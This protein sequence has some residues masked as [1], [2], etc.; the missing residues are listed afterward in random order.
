MAGA[1]VV[2][3]DAW[4]MPP[5]PVA[6]LLVGIVV[7]WNVA[8]GPLSVSLY[9]LVLLVMIGPC[10]WRWL[11]GGAGRVRVTDIALVLFCL[12]CCL[13]LAVVHGPGRAIEAGGMLI[14]ETAGTYFLARCYIRTVDDFR[15]TAGL[16]FLLIAFVA[17]FALV[18]AITGRNLA[19]DLFASVLPTYPQSYD[20]IRWGLK[21]VQS[22]F[23]HPI[24]FGVCIGSAFTLTH[25]VLGSGQPAWRRWFKSLL[26]L[27][28]A[29][30]SL[31]SGPFTALAAQIMLLAWAGITGRFA[32]KWHL[33]LALLAVAYIAIDLSSN[34][35]VFQFYISRFSF[36]R[37]TAWLRLL[38]WEYGTASVWAHPVFGIGFGDWVRPKWMTDSMDMFWL[39]HAVRHGI[40]AGFLMLLLPVWS[41][42]SIGLRKDIGARAQN[43]RLAYLITLTGL[44][45]VGWTVHFWGA[46]YVCF[47]FILGAGVWLGESAVDVP[48]PAPEPARVARGGAGVAHL[49]APRVPRSAR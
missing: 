35:S 32:Y 16:F 38:I 44:F 20:G 29:G 4:S 6:M 12:W 11:S 48:A 15:A 42:V 49:A 28:T 8:V 5:W 37:S 41:L 23:E 22:V 17:P 40:P 14:V 10:L 2:A 25:I 36:D 1:G 21:R 46:A 19:M 45:I 3:S 26:V 47:L 27:V 13:S 31:S 39:I 7:P 43:C 18:E 34:Q 33:L 30:L 24:L 9:R